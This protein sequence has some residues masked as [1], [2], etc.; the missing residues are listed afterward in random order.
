LAEMVSRQLFGMRISLYY[1]E[2]SWLAPIST[3]FPPI[4]MSSMHCTWKWHYCVL[5]FSL[6]LTGQCL[7]TDH[8]QIPGRGDSSP[9]GVQQKS[10]PWVFHSVER[11]W[12]VSVSMERKLKQNK[13]ES[14]SMQ[15]VV[16]YCYMKLLHSKY[17]MQLSIHTHTHTHTLCFFTKG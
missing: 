13:M 17:K 7:V 6:P 1:V 8:K 12:W 9:T 14:I 10:F 11:I 4:K 15:L 16:K 2:I 5:P 3:I